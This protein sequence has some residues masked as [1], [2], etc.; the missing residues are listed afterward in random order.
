MSISE[1]KETFIKRYVDSIK[2]TNKYDIER[3]ARAVAVLHPTTRGPIVN[4]GYGY[5]IELIA[6]IPN[7]NK[8]LNRKIEPISTNDYDKIRQIL[9]KNNLI[10]IRTDE[11]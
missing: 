4:W 8:L 3:A 9:F 6:V 7:D 1:L 2:E 10:E 11:I 5:G